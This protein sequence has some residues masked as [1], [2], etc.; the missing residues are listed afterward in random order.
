MEQ[1]K[2]ENNCI[3]RRSAVNAMTDAQLAAEMEES[4]END[5][6]GS[7]E[8]PKERQ[9]ALWNRIAC[10]IADDSIST[11]TVPK[12]HRILEFMKIAALFISPL[13]L[14]VCVYMFCQMQHAPM[15]TVVETA[16]GE[17]ASVTLPDGTKVK[18]NHD[19]RLSYDQSAFK[20][21]SRTVN[22][23]GEAWFSVNHDA[24]RPFVISARGLRVKVLGTVFTLRARSSEQKAYLLLEKGRVNV[25]STVSNASV[26]LRPVQKAVID[27]KS[28][29]IEVVRTTLDDALTA[30]QRGEMKYE[31]ESLRNVLSSIEDNYGVIFENENVMSRLDDRFSGTLPSDNL[32]EA[33]QILSYTY[34]VDFRVSHHKIMVYRKA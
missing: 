11:G 25:C 18:L 33:L 31:N 16:K 6:Y 20:D 15:V 26:T 30:W 8:M 17:K 13:L 12:R 1:N 9:D 34:R 21:V 32:N 27:F 7:V 3:S 29:N 5:S 4:W 24:S 23:D 22:I 28:N 2:K 14:A 10:E 19:T